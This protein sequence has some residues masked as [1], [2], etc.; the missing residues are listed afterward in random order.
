MEA[1]GNTDNEALYFLQL[2]AYALGS[3]V[4]ISFIL[5]IELIFQ[6][7]KKYN[8]DTLAKERKLFFMGLLFVSFLFAEYI[9]FNIILTFLYITLRWKIYQWEYFVVYYGYN[10]LW[11]FGCAINPM[12]YYRSFE[13]A[14]KFYHAFKF[15]LS[16]ESKC[17]IKL[18]LC[19][20]LFIRFL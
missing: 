12:I 6:T 7:R 3:A 18:H 1:Y 13:Y 15:I 16:D 17:I 19:Y 8:T 2:S 5:P 11:I 14:F 4:L 9:I 20:V 10:F